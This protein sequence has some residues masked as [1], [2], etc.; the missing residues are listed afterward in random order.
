MNDFKSLRVLDAFRWIFE[1]FDIDYPIMRKLIQLKLTMDSRRIP[2]IFNGQKQK[3]EGNQFIKSLWL[4][5]FYGLLLLTPFLFL[6]NQ[7]MFASSILFTVLM[8]ITITTMVS[9]FSAVLLDVRDKNILQSKPV[10]NRT[11]NAAKLM[12]IV[13]YLALLEGAF[14]I[15][16]L[17]VGI[18]RFGIFY[19]LIFIVSIVFV[20]C[21][22][23]VITAFTYLFILRFFSGEKLKDI[24]NYV[25]IFL[26]VAVMVSY[27]VMAHSFE[28]T[29][30]NLQYTFTWWHVFLPPLWYSAFF[31]V[32][33]NQDYSINM[34]ILMVC[35]IVIPLLMLRIYIKLMPT[36]ERSLSKLMSDTVRTKGKSHFFEDWTSKILCRNA[37][38][39]TFYRFASLMIRQERE[40]KLK[41]YPQIG[42]AIVIPF[43]MFFNEVRIDSLKEAMANENVYPLYFS[44]LMIPTVV[45]LLKFSGA[46]KGNWI[47]RATPI[48]NSKMF[49]SSTLKAA[50][51]KLFFPTFALL[52][53]VFIAMFSWAII[54]DLLIILLV[55]IMM[56]LLSYVLLNGEVYPF[57]NSHELTQ[58]NNTLKV[59]V[60]MVVIAA[61]AL[62]HYLIAMI[63]YA[64][65]IYMLILI[66]AVIVGWRLVF[67]EKKNHGHS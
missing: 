66:I 42:F 67:G 24:I 7:Y 50:I 62:V 29:Q 53:I 22:V 31:E 55:A 46:Y 5:L 20:S 59:L 44:A 51:V 13:I 8:F 1:K 25:Q 14:V 47:F 32:L 12:H 33:L 54:P 60:A 56:T 21:F 49:Y 23:V 35:G 10:S 37:Q 17:A 38:E 57:S 28:L 43:V 52:S 58:D 40:F 39:R 26:A 64:K 9:D 2:A 16:P 19:G 45:H 3:K 65:L 61:F 36:F 11:L 41:A 63:P 48:S 34:L 30:M 15:I 6:E 18:F 27:Q 4:Y